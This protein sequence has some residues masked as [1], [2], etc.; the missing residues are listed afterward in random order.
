MKNE[1]FKEIIIDNKE[2]GY[3]ISNRGRVY[4]MKTNKELIP[5][6][7]KD[8]Y[9]VV[10]LYVD[11]TMYY[12]RVHKLVME[13]FN[14]ALIYCYE[15]INHIDG[16]KANNDIDNLEYCSYEYNNWHFRNILNGQEQPQKAK[17]RILEMR[18]R[19]K[20]VTADFLKQQSENPRGIKDISE[21]ELEEIKELIKAK[22]PSRE[23]CIN[24]NIKNSVIK[25]LIARNTEGK[26]SDEVTESDIRS[27]CEDIKSGEYSITEIAN[28]RRVRRSVVTSIYYKHQKFKHIWIDYFEE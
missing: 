2:T 7:D 17:E 12:Y 13:Y 9:L 22:I 25:N 26:S 21:S 6:I 8:G 15:T 10:A 3:L 23:I 24:Y 28:R 4:S 16:D 27:I 11:K 5:S 19:A 1:I 20:Q 18:K 14:E